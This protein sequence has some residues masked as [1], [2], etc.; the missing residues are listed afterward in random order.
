M[1]P[2]NFTHSSVNDSIFDLLAKSKTVVPFS[3]RKA[4]L[5][6]T[7]ER[8]SSISDFDDALT[9]GLTN[10]RGKN[11]QLSSHV[12]FRFY[13]DIKTF[14]TKPAYDLA[15]P[16]ASVAAKLHKKSKDEPKEYLKT[17]RSH[18]FDVLVLAA[19][20]PKKDVPLSKEEA[21]IKRSL[22]QLSLLLDHYIGATVTTGFDWK[23]VKITS[24]LDSIL[25]TTSKVAVTVHTTGTKEELSFIQW[26]LAICVTMKKIPS[27][28]LANDP[29][30]STLPLPRTESLVVGDESDAVNTIPTQ[31]LTIQD[32][33]DFTEHETAES[34]DLLRD[35][36]SQSKTEKVKLVQNHAQTMAQFEEQLHAER[37]AKKK[38]E[39][40]L[41]AERRRHKD[42]EE[43]LTK[44][45]EEMQETLEKREK[46]VKRLKDTLDDVTVETKR[47]ISAFENLIK[48]RNELYKAKFAKQEAL[49]KQQNKLFKELQGQVS[50][51]FK[52]FRLIQ[53]LELIDT[54]IME[55][56][57]KKLPSLHNISN[58]EAS[59]VVIDD[60]NE[61]IFADQAEQ[62]FEQFVANWR[63]EVELQTKFLQEK[64]NVYFKELK[65]HESRKQIH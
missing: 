14:Q 27:S 61:A 2:I 38:L 50:G 32:L 36:L 58:I 41:R 47:Q 29:S 17:L 49:F 22:Y 20:M 5:E 55:V 52:S 3:R 28:C 43:K 9:V 59:G 37:E 6:L 15:A 16:R 54:K 4:D 34:R 48:S 11:G 10:M 40:D 30:S 51:T 62:N 63:E 56:S 42:K 1:Y 60:N 13:L 35:A 46:D 31:S 65:K 7:K 19:V 21:Q 45:L 24:L 18:N 44:K 64:F 53:Y 26:A 8:I 33:Q 57:Q 12:L 39:I 25:H 23:T